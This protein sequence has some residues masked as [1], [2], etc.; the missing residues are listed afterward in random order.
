MNKYFEFPDYQELL[1]KINNCKTE[2]EKEAK[3][4]EIKNALDNINKILSREYNWKK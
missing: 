4:L 3:Y 2:E 1:D